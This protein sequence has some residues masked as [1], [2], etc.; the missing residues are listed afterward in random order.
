MSEWEWISTKKLM[1]K[2]GEPILISVKYEGTETFVACLTSFG[3]RDY[4]TDYEEDRADIEIER[5]EYW[6]PLPKAPKE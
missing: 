3:G 4:F 1:P 6:M 5:V 2:K